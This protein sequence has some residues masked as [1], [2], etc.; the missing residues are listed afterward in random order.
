MFRK[1]LTAT[2]AALTLSGAV[3]TSSTAAE[4]RGLNK[5]AI[6]AGIV[7]AVVGLVA[8]AASAR[9]EPTYQ[10]PV[11]YEPGYRPVRYE[12]CGF[13]VRPVFDEYGR[14]VGARRVP[15]C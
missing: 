13:A 6:G 7:G 5:L 10:R 15:A 9:Q 4:A 12:G 3:I 1:T 14:Q 8:G 11:G 2:V